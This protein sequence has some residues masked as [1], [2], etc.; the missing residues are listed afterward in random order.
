MTGTNLQR[1]RS[2]QGASLILLV[3]IIGLAFIVT[4]AAFLVAASNGQ[5]TARLASAKVDIATREDVVM[6]EILQQTA[7]GLLP[8]NAGVSGTPQPWTAILTSAV[9]PLNAGNTYLNS[10]ELAFVKSNLPSPAPTVVIPANLGD[11][12]ATPV[13]GIFQGYSG[14]LP[15]GGTSGLLNVVTAASAS[16]SPSTLYNA[17]VQPPLM[18]WSSGSLSSTTALSTPQEFFLGSQYSSS[19]STAYAPVTNL[20]PSSR[21]GNIAYPNIRFG[22]KQSGDTNFIARRVWW[23]IPVLYST[24]QQIV[25]VLASASA[26]VSPTPTIFRYPSA[27]AYYVLSVYEIPSQLPISGNANLQIGLNADGTAWG[28]TI[29]V[30]GSIYGG[31]VQLSGG[32]FTGVSSRQQVNVL[33]GATV[34]GINYGTSNLFDQP[35]TGTGTRENIALTKNPGATAPVSVAGN[36]GKVLLVPVMPGNQFYMSVATTPTN[37]DLYARPYYRCRIRIIISGT[38][39]TII[40]SPSQTPQINTAAGAITVQTI[41]SLDALKLPD[42]ILG[43]PDSA[44]ATNTTVTQSSI[45]AGGLPAYLNYTSTAAG[46]RNLLIVDVPALVTA[47]GGGTL[48]QNAPQLYSIYIGSNPTTEPAASPSPAPPPYTEP[49]IGITNTNDLSA[50]TSGLSIVS[51]QTLYLLGSFNQVAT[52]PQINTSIYAP[53]IRYGM[54]GT[55]ASVSLTGQISV[56]PSSSATPAVNPLSLV[57]ASGTPISASS[58]S[59]SF[60]EITRPAQ[61]PPIPRL[62]LMF[63]I[64]KQRT[65]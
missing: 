50:F 1:K 49:G 57:N 11:T 55:A 35:G 13:L 18:N 34:G 63:T 33:V 24:T 43:F 14:N 26:Q 38:N 7:T 47:L 29:Q 19:S 20:S 37:W 64:E 59:A 21:W 46:D 52:T 15:Y 48:I 56:D 41:V 45:A 27:T 6:R 23:L 30:A 58:I 16:P 3:G 4:V 5:D 9:N 65:N 40:Y 10:T 60:G 51:N 54:S 17:T 62:S 44:A 8:G 28:S 31:Q 36:D 42:Q 12:G 22:Y 39:S 53:Q 2:K 61:I 25:Q 32:T